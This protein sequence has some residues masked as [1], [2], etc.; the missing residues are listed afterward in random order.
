LIILGLSAAATFQVWVT[1]QV[2]RSRV[3]ERERKILQT[4]LI[5]LVPVLGALLVFTVLREDAKPRQNP[6][7][8]TRR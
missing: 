6:P 8:D 7:S 5:W 3:F 2:W 4:Q 1:W